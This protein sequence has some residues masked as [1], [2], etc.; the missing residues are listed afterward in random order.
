MH[1]DSYGVEPMC[2]QLAFAPSVY[3][4][5]AKWVREPD[6]RSA[7]RCQDDLDMIEIDRV[8]NEN[9][10]VYGAGKIFHQLRREGKKIAMSTIRRLM[11][12]MGIQGVT[13]GK[14]VRTTIP[15]KD[16]ACPLDKVNRNFDPAGPNLLWVSDFTY[17]RTWSGMVYV[18]FVIDAYAR[19]IV[20]WKV[21]STANTAFVFD[22]LEQA[23]W[24]RKPKGKH[25]VHHSDRGSQYLSIRYS[26][27]LAEAG[28]NPSVGSVGDSYDNA[29]AE[30]TIGL[31]K[32]EVYERL[33]PWKSKQDVEIAVMNWVDW[34]N[35]RR[36]HSSIGNVPPVEAEEKYH[37]PCHVIALAA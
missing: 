19:R 16:A 32:T 7:R 22:A 10:G 27:R 12:A 15:A 18:A 31:F 4:R 30:S 17:C 13:R 21:S 14:A 5:H 3:H 33:G 6:S 11:K 1:R 2:R 36:L 37:E 20:G 24:A 9:F 35:N 23:I 25:L 28:I 26:E 34:Y 8:F 29:L